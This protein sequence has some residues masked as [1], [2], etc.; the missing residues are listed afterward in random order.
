MGAQLC[1]HV[2]K[3]LTE[4]DFQVFFANTM[5][6]KYFRG[7]GGGY[8]IAQH[9][10][11]GYDEI[12]T[13]IMDTP[14]VGVGDWSPLKASIMEEG[15]QYIPTPL[16]KIQEI[17]GEDLPVIDNEM[18]K[19]VGDALGLENKTHYDVSS[20]VPIISF[21]MKHRGEQVFTVSW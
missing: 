4:R 3:G 7:L 6:S 20:D 11:L 10:A 14:S 8:T 5:G 19:K 1:I 21:L 9:E 15:D 16:E 13:K 18:I 2:F 17:V 12:L